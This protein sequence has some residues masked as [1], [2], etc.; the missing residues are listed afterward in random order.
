MS[1]WKHCS[2]CLTQSDMHDELETSSRC[3]HCSLC[4]RDI[5]N[6]SI[7]KFAKSF[8][9][10][11]H[12][13][14]VFILCFKPLTCSLSFKSLCSST[15][16]Y[17][18]YEAD[19][20]ES[21]KNVMIT[22]SSISIYSTFWWSELILLSLW[23]ETLLIVIDTTI[24]EIAI[25]KILTDFKAFTQVEWYELTYMLTLTAFQLIYDNVYKFFN[26]KL[27]YLVSIVIFEDKH[28]INRVITR[29]RHVRSKH[30]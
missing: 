19:R 3:I 11:E 8:V 14:Q 2:F 6:Y 15:S 21:L 4:F 12:A 10:Y 25:L 24:I 18:S 20:Y 13:T 26:V 16:F 1:D 29:S 28:E 22:L 23:L 9:Q 7:T 27:V 30:S 17:Q 5:V